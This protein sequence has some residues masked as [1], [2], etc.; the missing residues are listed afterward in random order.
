M[1]RPEDAVAPC[2]LEC[3]IRAGRPGG[4]APRQPGRRPGPPQSA[5]P[6]RAPR[7]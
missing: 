7:S 1:G 4:R 6:G 5:R 2:H 3:G